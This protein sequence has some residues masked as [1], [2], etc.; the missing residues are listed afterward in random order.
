MA[1]ND[2]YLKM[3]DEF[4]RH[5]NYDEIFQTTLSK[6]SG[7][8]QL[9][10]VNS[11]LIVGPGDGKHEVPFVMQCAKNTSEVR[12]VEPDHDSAD[13]LRARLR[14]SLP[15]VD[16]HVVETNIQSWKRLDV[17]VDLVLMFHVLYYITPRERKDLFKKLHDDWLA[18]DGHAVVVSSSRTKCR[19]NANEIYERLGTPM[20]TWEDMEADILEAGF[21]KQHAQEM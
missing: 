6:L 7:E 15:R 8:L 21:V 18:V 10:S 13:S 1:T 14:N 12:A 4:C 11:C 20:H 2:D 3:Y 17:P 5:D 19:G 9:D 16:S